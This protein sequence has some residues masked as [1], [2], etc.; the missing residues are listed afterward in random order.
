MEMRISAIKSLIFKWKISR[1]IQKNT[2]IKKRNKSL[3]IKRE[4]F[5]QMD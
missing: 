1:K 2:G 5:I 3:I 4:L